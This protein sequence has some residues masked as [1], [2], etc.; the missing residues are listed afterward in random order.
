MNVTPTAEKKDYRDSHFKEASPLTRI[1]FNRDSL[2]LPFGHPNVE[3][4]NLNP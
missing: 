4:H 2:L 3:S 1:V